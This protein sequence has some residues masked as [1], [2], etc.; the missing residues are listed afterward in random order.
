MSRRIAEV[1]VALLAIAVIS[2]ASVENTQSAKQARNYTEH[3]PIYIY[4]DAEFTAANGVVSGSGT[5]TDPYI[6]EGWE[7]Y[8]NN[9]HGIHVKDTLA[10]FTIRNCKIY[11]G[12]A[13]AKIGIFFDNVNYGKIENCKIYDNHNGIYFH[14]DI[15]E[16]IRCEIYN[17]SLYGIY[18]PYSD[19]NNIT[20]NYVYNNSNYGIS[21]GS[22]HNN[23]ITGNY[24]YNNP[25]Y[26]ICLGNAPN[27]NIT[28]NYV[29]NS[30]NCGI[31]IK[32]LSN[33]NLVK[34]NII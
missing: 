7:I 1:F 29:Y 23:N 19:H 17:N 10:N 4:G 11:G 25:K 13:N 22:A 20:G 5:A 30:P 34:D 16:I 26:G 27:N 6:I 32:Y 8:A 15:S 2:L 28:G 31:Y 18:S 33:N 24:V 12:K 3:A 14:A 9:T 21:L